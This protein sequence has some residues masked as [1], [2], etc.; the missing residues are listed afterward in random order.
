MR[1]GIRRAEFVRGGIRAWR[2]SAPREFAGRNSRGGIRAQKGCEKIGDSFPLQKGAHSKGLRGWG[3]LKKPFISAESGYL[4]LCQ[5]SRPLTSSPGGAPE[6]APPGWE[7]LGPSLGG[8]TDL[9]PL[10]IIQVLGD[11]R[12]TDGSPTDGRIPDGRTDRPHRMPDG[13]PTKSPGHS[14][15]IHLIIF[16]RV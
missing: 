2:N 6:G 14:P 16:A 9:V 4:P 13:R 11:L 15:D 8:L 10:A 12:R 7:A 1:G 3:T 5:G